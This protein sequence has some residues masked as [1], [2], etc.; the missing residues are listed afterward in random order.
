MNNFDI[1]SIIYIRGNRYEEIFVFIDHRT[2][3]WGERAAF[4]LEKDTNIKTILIGYPTKGGYTADS[5]RYKITFDNF[6]MEMSLSRNGTKLSPE[7]IEGV[8][9]TPDYYTSNNYESIEIVKHLT[10]DEDL[11]LPE[12]YKNNIDY[13]INNNVKKW[14][15]H[16]YY[17]RLK[18]KFYYEQ[19]IKNGGY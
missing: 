13:C 14:Q 10:K 9:L 18:A 19:N 8:G 1:I 16:S 12:I 11:R 2:Y 5:I 4:L 3:S 17:K 7:L 6:T 15:T